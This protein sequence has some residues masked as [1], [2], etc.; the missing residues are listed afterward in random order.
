MTVWDFKIADSTNIFFLFIDTKAVIKHP[1]TIRRA[2]IG[3]D[4]PNCTVCTLE[5][6]NFILLAAQFK[7]VQAKLCLICELPAQE[8][9]C[10]LCVG[11]SAAVTTMV[12]T[13]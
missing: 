6:E 3:R 2:H 1:T 13:G 12:L 5:N 11:S 9:A 7:V 8:H 4:T 10:M